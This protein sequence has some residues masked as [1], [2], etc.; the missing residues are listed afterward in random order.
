VQSFFTCFFLQ[1]RRQPADLCTCSA[2][3]QRK[4]RPEHHRDA[5]QSSIPKLHI[6]RC[7]PTRMGQLHGLPEA[8]IVT[9]SPWH[10]TGPRVAF[11][12]KLRF[13]LAACVPAAMAPVDEWIVLHHLSKLLGR[14]EVQLVADFLNYGY[15]EPMGRSWV[16]FDGVNGY[17][18]ISEM[19]TLGMLSSYRWLW[20]WGFVVEDCE[21]DPELR[22]EVH[23]MRNATR[24]R[25]GLPPL[26]GPVILP[27]A[28]SDSESE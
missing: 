23:M 15:L 12:F 27:I 17:V 28:E 9:N 3:R 14:D 24:L 8:I 6:P 1:P 22:E 25:H 10:H 11:N 7:R 5:K 2:T 18:D 4:G 16:T 13:Q 26:P 21:M 20:R 19:D